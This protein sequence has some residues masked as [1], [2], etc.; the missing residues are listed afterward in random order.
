MSG[1]L[2]SLFFGLTGEETGAI[3]M[4]GA[5]ETGADTEEEQAEVKG[6]GAETIDTWGWKA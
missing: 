4:G 5:L 2:Y 3:G 1:P 6:P